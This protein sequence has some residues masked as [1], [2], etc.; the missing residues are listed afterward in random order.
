MRV[1]RHRAADAEHVDAGHGG[2]RQPR[3][4]HRLEHLVPRRP[5]LHHRRPGLHVHR[6]RVQAAHVDDEPARVRR[7]PAQRV[8]RATHRHGEVVL[9]GVGER[10]PDP[11]LVDRPHDPEHGGA[12][13]A[14]RVRHRAAL[15]GQPTRVCRR[16]R[17]RGRAALLDDGQGRH[18]ADDLVLGRHRL[19]RP[20]RVLRPAHHQDHQQRD[21]HH[22]PPHHPPASRPVRSG[23]TPRR[24][25][26][27]GHGRPVSSPSRWS[28]PIEHPTSPRHGGRQ[29][30][31]AADPSG[32]VRVRRGP[33]PEA[34]P[35]P[36]H[37]DPALAGQLLEEVGRLQ[38]R[39]P[40]V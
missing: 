3:R 40:V 14:A 9:G 5:G 39:V 36:S 33:P 23:R 8:L 7:L 26:G 15:L 32:L 38:V 30:R 19:P 35:L 17:R 6:D 22:G 24:G 11:G 37:L 4:V 12:G 25:A 10:R 20:Q 28:W 18:R 21:D 1:D 34:L 16:V 31:C 2:D 29:R 13:Q 27:R